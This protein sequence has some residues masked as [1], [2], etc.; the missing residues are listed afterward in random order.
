M[1]EGRSPTPPA[2]GR[3]PEL[4]DAL[5]SFYGRPAQAANRMDPIQRVVKVELDRRI[6]LL[7]SLA[8]VRLEQA[9]KGK[10]RAKTWDLTL[11]C[12]KRPQLAISTTG[13]STS[14]AD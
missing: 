4:Q 13:S 1:A 6:A 14:P 8:E 3:P 11:S 5:T 10:H 7:G 2:R 9:V 12:A